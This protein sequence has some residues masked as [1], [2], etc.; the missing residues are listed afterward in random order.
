MRRGVPFSINKTKS[1]RSRS[2]RP[3]QISARAA[4]LIMLAGA[5]MGCDSF[6]FV[7]P[8]PEELRE[9][10]GAVP[11]AVTDTFRPPIASGELPAQSKSIDVVLGPHDADEAEIWKGAI[12]V[13]AGLD[14]SR[15][16]ILGPA[17]APDTQASIIRESLAHHPGVLVID[18]SSPVD[19]PV[20]REIDEARRQGIPVV[21]VGRTPAGE[22]TESKPAGAAEAK[23]AGSAALPSPLIVVAPKPLEV[24]AKQLVTTILRACRDSEVDP[25]KTAILVSNSKGGPYAQECATALQGALKDAGITKID[26][27]RF[28]ANDKNSVA[29]VEANLKAN[30]KTVTI[31]AV[32]SMTSAVVKDVIKNDAS[33]RFFV[34]GCYATDDFKGDLTKV[35]QIGAVAEF[36]PTRMMRK[37]VSTAASVAQ[38][39]DVP[40]LIEFPIDIAEPMATPAM[41]RAKAIES[42]KAD[43]G[44]QIPKQ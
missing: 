10:A 2:V 34:G 22:K 27:L 3:R 17:E 28:S 44:P 1:T 21:V 16:R 18:A 30:P 6:S 40:R 20:L 35:I 39:R 7:P 43:G 24:S 8:K 11:A 37:G 32:D 13:Q 12:R 25:G 41:L 9:S 19:P 4:C 42:K 5:L 26:E 29:A 38:G 14:R 31:F 36:A 23:S 15:L 33:H